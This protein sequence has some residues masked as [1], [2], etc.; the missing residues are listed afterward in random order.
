L[1]Y[2]KHLQSFNHIS[3]YFSQM[4]QV[5][6]IGSG[7]VATHL[8][9][10]I[11][12][13]PK[14]AVIQVYNRSLKGLE[15]IKF[16]G[17]KTSTINDLMDADCYLIA[18]S[19]DAIH[20]IS[21]SLPFQNRLVVHTSGGVSINELDSKNRQGVFYPLQ[22]FSKE[23][24]V[25]FSEVPLCLE[26]ENENDLKLLNELAR[27]ISNTVFE[28]NS[29]KRKQLHLAAVFV[30]NF[31]NHLYHIGHNLTEENGIPFSI[32]IPL[33]RETAEKIEQATPETM[34][35]GPAKR[36][37]IKTLEK[38]LEILNKPLQKEIYKLLSRSIQNTYGREKL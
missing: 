4:I 10:A 2:Q 33:I 37:D 35:T 38:H 15:T 24:E 6:I 31:V 36:N 7:N 13:S 21:V 17:N 30:C 25:N 3:S 19:D 32:L 28:I 27:S 29:E 22:T 12:T 20:P 1:D 18:V 16:N 11:E 9:K 8:V 23:R 14:A 5:V 26:A 34:Q